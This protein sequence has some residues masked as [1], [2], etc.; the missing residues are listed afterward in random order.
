MAKTINNQNKPIL[1]LSIQ[2]RLNGLSFCM[3]D[4]QKNEITWYK[5]TDFPRDFNP[6]KVLGEIEL[7]Y[8]KEETLQQEIDEVVILFS[9]DLYSLIPTEFFNEDEASNYLKFNTRILKTD[10]VAND[11]LESQEMVNVY[12]PYTNITN[13]FFD[14][15][16]EFEY[17]HSITVFAQA[18]LNVNSG[19]ETIIYLNNYSGYYDLA[20]V[21]NKKLLLCNTFSYETKEDFIYYLLFT[22]EQLELDPSSFPLYLLGEISEDSP[23]YDIT[24]K[25]IKNVNFIE[26]EFHTG[27]EHLM[28][29]EFQR[30]AFLLLKSL[31]CE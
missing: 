13:Y 18:I 29:Q 12:I 8:E 22:A 15:Y 26:P 16:G 23:F 2:V 11:V 7:I 1:K 30:E 9:N 6:V 19:D 10:V 25:Y 17:K 24:Y 4:C 20:V 3:L 27:P 28:T 31:Q 5:K 21:K 14:K